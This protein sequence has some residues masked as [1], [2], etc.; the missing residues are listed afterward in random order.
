MQRVFNGL[1]G[2][3]AVITLVWT[4]ADTFVRLRLA[5]AVLLVIAASAITA[6][7]PVALKLVVDGFASGGRGTHV[8]ALI[9]LYVLTQWLARIVGESR[10]LLYARAERRMSRLLGERLFSHVM[11]LPLRFHLGRRTGA[12]GQTLENG[13]IGY[14]LVLHTLVFSLLPVVTELGTVVVIL[15]RLDEPGF[16]LLFLGALTVYAG[17]FTYAAMITGSAAQTASAAQVEAHA[18]MTDSLLNYETVK[19]LAAERPVQ[20]RASRA[21][22][23][24]EAGWVGFYRRYAWNGV[25]VAAI[26]SAFLAVTILRAAREVQAGV[27][28][29]GTF[30]LVNSYML[31]IVRPVELFGYALQSLSQG[32]AFLEDSLR[33]LRE[34]PESSAHPG[35]VR[36]ASRLAGGATLEFHDVSLAY[37]PGH[38]VL[39]GVTFSMAAGSTVA[40]VGGSGAGKSSIVRLMVRLV[41]PESGRIL[42]DGV[43]LGQMGLSELR[44]QIAVVPQDTM[45][46]DDT[47]AGNIGFGNAGCGRDEIV[48]AARLAQLHEFVMSLPHGYDTRVGERGVRLSGGERQRVSIA[49]AAIRNPRIFVFDEATSS[50]DSATE[51]EI[52]RNLR[53]IARLGTTLIIAHRLSTIV[54]ADEILVLEKG[55]I[56]ERGTHSGLLAGNGRYASLWSAQQSSREGS[57]HS[58]DDSAL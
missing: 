52:A 40:I 2:L 19:F 47:I 9:G 24:V 10:G 11:Q 34:P 13:V 32:V 48:L 43:P 53:E 33:L 5:A 25:A 6:L 45:L 42:L 7:G 15:A 55:I 46:F 23:A 1:T 27:M 51:R 22:A 14:Q 36:P 17:A 44:R 12:V 20:E 54:H 38:R 41:E 21:L 26:F 8:S 28:T 30:V 29:V 3:R 4:D 58:S 49:R 39:R 16:L 35:H 31:Q 57:A 50:L 37:Q 56:V 18:V